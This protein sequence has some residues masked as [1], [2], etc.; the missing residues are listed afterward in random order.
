MSNEFETI[1]VTSRT[2][3][4]DSS[5]NDDGCNGCYPVWQMHSL[6]KLCVDYALDVAY[7]F[8]NNT[9][10]D[11]EALQRSLSL[12]LKSYPTFSGRMDPLNQNQ[13]ILNDLGALFVLAEE[14]N[15]V[16]AEIID[17][18]IQLEQDRFI[19]YS[20]SSRQLWKGNEPLLRVKLTYIKDGCV[21]GIWGSH[22]L[23][24]GATFYG[25]M[26]NWS[27][28]CD[29]IVNGV[30]DVVLPDMCLDNNRITYCTTARRTKEQV[31]KEIE[32]LNWTTT[33]YVQA[34]AS[35][36]EVFLLDGL[37]VHHTE[38]TKPFRFS[39]DALKRMKAIAE[40]DAKRENVDYLTT[41]E[42]L[43]AFLCQMMS[44]L[45]GF[46]AGTPMHHI[47]MLNWRSRL[48]NIT[49]NFVGNASYQIKTCGLV[50]GESL[51]TI[52]GKIHNGLLRYKSNTAQL[53]DTIMLYLEVLYHD[54]LA[55]SSDPLTLPYVSR[56][57]R[58]VIT[59]NFAL[60]PI[61][62]VPF[63]TGKQPTKAIPHHCG[64]QIL[65]WPTPDNQGVD[66]YFQGTTSKAIKRLPQ[67]SAWFTE[68]LKFSNPDVLSQNPVVYKSAH[69]LP[70]I[71]TSTDDELEANVSKLFPL[72]PVHVTQF[73]NSVSGWKR[74]VL[75]SQ[76]TNIAIFLFI[77]SLFLL[78]ILSDKE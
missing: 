42:V 64:D 15:T 2:F 52:A 32:R 33:N 51:G 38:R 72:S 31:Y 44:S 3:E 69:S 61:Y 67:N 76:V 41:N 56:K 53:R 27:K 40:E 36:G 59:N 1:F 8:D 71:D 10:I 16:A 21:L 66:V 18:E 45:Y 12:I 14:P 65:I 62:Q 47:T 5:V 73:N 58:S 34:G 4:S 60:Y 77:V 63:G 29:Q 49:D 7:V 55:H 39:A 50:A 22:V 37:L 28:V 9:R 25:F 78:T 57:P 75:I 11:K 70:P 43:S 54:I 17:N 35:F 6:D 68:L 19:D 24:D 74:R 20:K 48:A 26:H 13:V 23:G 30:K 46:E